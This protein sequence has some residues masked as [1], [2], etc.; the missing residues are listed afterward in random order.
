MGGG[1]GD[2]RWRRPHG[3]TSET[4]R[5][6]PAL[7]VLL[8]SEDIGA[9]QAEAYGYIN[10]A[11][12]DADLDAFVET[13]ATRIAKFD[14][15]AI[16]QTK[17]L[18]DTSL[19]PD[20]ELGAGWGRVHRFARATRRTRGNQGSDGA[21]LPQARGR[22]KSARILPGPN[23]ALVFVS[24]TGTAGKDDRHEIRDQDRPAI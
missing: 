16:A 21:R 2:G 9:D 20:V 24:S 1:C 22:R 12:P 6:K 8:S 3:T 13:L 11:L 14:K 23:R 5:P 7:E 15:W 4:H 18:V 17:R 19:P 10:R